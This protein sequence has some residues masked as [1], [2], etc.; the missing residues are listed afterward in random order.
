MALLPW[1]DVQ[2]NG[3]TKKGA[4]DY[5]M[6]SYWESTGHHVNIGAGQPNLRGQGSLPRE[7]IPWLGSIFR[8]K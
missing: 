2:F 7:V 6:V 5:N 3:K 4:S 8:E 1:K